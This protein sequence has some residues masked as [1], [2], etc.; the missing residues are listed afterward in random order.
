MARN[1]RRRPARERIQSTTTWRTKTVSQAARAPWPGSCRRRRAQPFADPQVDVG[2][3]VA[4]GDAVAG[5][6]RQ[7][8]GRVLV[9]ERPPA[10]LGI[11][12][13]DR[14]QVAVREGR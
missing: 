5:D 13:E 14:T 6:E 8:G 12:I 10:A 3:V 11:L 4:V 2:R 7:H 1:I 9:D